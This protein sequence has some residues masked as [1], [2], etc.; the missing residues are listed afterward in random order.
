MLT[1]TLRGLVCV[2]AFFALLQPV[3]L[4]AQT[5]VDAT[6]AALLQQ[7]L[8]SCVNVFDVPGISATILF[9]GDRIWQGA[10]GLSHIYNQTP[11]TTDRL[12]FQASVTKML[13]SAM[14]L[15]LV[16]EG[17]LSLD[18]SLGHYLPNFPH[19]K[20]GIKIRH[21]LNHRSGLHD[22]IADNPASSQ[23][24]F[25][26]PFFIW[27]PEDAI[28]S[29][30]KAP[31]FEE[32]A[33]FSYSNTNYVLLGLIIEN[34]TGTSFAEAL[35]T[36]F[37]EPY[38]MDKTFFP[39]FNVINGPVATGW[40][41]FTSPNV[42]NTDAA[43]VYTPCSY[44][45]I[46]TAGALVALPADIAKFTRLLYSGQIISDSMMTILKTCTNVNFGNGCNGYGHGSMRY[47]F[48]GKTY[49]GHAGDFSGFTQLS[50]HQEQEEVTLTLSINRNNAPR[51]PIA[52]A[53][54]QVVQDNPLATRAP[55]V[56][57]V[58]ENMIIWPN[59]ATDG[60]F[61]EGELLASGNG[62]IEV[63]DVTG[64]T[65]ITKNLGQLPSGNFRQELDVAGLPAGLYACRLV[66]ENGSTSTRLVMM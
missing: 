42:F 38:G 40:T 32:N 54:L 47:N 28:F 24:W 36:R 49:F 8:D 20:S 58:V 4:S 30:I 5:P 1:K 56:M 16:D 64:R 29:Y 44:S 48:L 12:F 61:I 37:L 7:K 26:T 62:L 55:E 15:Q 10:S 27:D 60:I 34:V 21:L 22:F 33:G 9:P 63:T 66:M 23:T 11:M 2:M 3:S 43:P 18:D 14:I 65:L 41:S 13:V 52:A 25:T 57:P 6:M 53:L 17:A 50:V 19:I 59:P 31:Y 51:G 46:F 39:P 45:M 35:H